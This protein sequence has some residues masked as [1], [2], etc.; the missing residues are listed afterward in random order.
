MT[1]TELQAVLD[2]L[3]SLKLALIAKGHLWTVE[4]T[5]AFNHAVVLVKNEAHLI[6][7]SQGLKWP[8]TVGGA[9]T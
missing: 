7:H 1:T 4:E 8:S 9:T 5:K 2:G 6:A 3:D